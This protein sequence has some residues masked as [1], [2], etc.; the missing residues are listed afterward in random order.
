MPKIE[1]TKEETNNL[2]MILRKSKLGFSY[3]ELVIA[4]QPIVVK[5]EQSLIIEENN[6]KEDSNKKTTKEASKA[7]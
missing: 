1:L 7:A 4:I 6:E 3:E 5:L 2:I